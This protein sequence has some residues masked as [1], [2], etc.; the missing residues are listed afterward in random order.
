[1]TLDLTERVKRALENL[2]PRPWLPEI[3]AGLVEAGWEALFRRTGLTPSLYGTA[4]VIARDP[5]APRHVLAHLPASGAIVS[6]GGTVQIEIP[7]ESLVHEYE[8][9]G[10]KFYTAEEIERGNL[11]GRVEEALSLLDRVP[12]LAATVAA[13]VRSLHLIKP[14][15]EDYDVSFSEPHVPFSVF[16]SVPRGG[17]E[18]NALRVAEA[19]V[20]EAMHLQ[21][22]LIEQA[23]PL[24]NSVNGKYFSP[25]RE[26]YRTAQGILHALYVFCVIDKFLERFESN[27]PICFSK[28]SNYAALRHAQ[29]IEQV[30]EIVS[31][32]GCPDLT[33]HGTK[34]VEQL[35]HIL[36]HIKTD[37]PEESLV[38]SS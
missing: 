16:V 25:W 11:P 18:V 3:T 29:I 20:H 12:T 36:I 13:L 37:N 8:A 17:G 38:P 4:R 33:I 35:I 28:E 14:D 22:T 6:A 31:F 30:H 2:C 24:V 19:I 32:Q 15:D 5:S 7:D 21:L 27:Q 10:I 9:G 34:F 26:E 23:V 1:M